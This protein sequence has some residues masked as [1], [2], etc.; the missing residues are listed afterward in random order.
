MKYAHKVH[1][2]N[3]DSNIKHELSVKKVVEKG[4]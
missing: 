2:S 4:K 1:S 3:K